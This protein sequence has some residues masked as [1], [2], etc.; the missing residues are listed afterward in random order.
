M[1]RHFQLIV[2]ITLLVTA[3]QACSSRLTKY[4]DWSGFIGIINL[5]IG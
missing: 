1:A 4:N 3:R 2:K 5:D